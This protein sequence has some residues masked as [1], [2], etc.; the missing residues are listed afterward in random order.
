MLYSINKR[1]GTF[2]YTHEGKVGGEGGGGGGRSRG[3][4]GGG[5]K[6]KK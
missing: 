4:V 2:A 5:G 3:E 1:D 6:G